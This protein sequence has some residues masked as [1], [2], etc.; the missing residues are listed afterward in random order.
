MLAR[1]VIL[2][3]GIHAQTAA[4]IRATIQTVDPFIFAGTDTGGMLFSH[5]EQNS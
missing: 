3:L 2:F 1:I 4:I 5:K